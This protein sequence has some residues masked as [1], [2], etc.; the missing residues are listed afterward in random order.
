MMQKCGVFQD[1][2]F[3]LVKKSPKPSRFPHDPRT[4]RNR[5]RDRR[6]RKLVGRN[7]ELL[8]LEGM[9]IPEFPFGRSHTEG[10]R[11]DFP[12]GLPSGRLLPSLTVDLGSVATVP[13]VPVGNV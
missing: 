12:S 8:I 4:R 9:E 10:Q 5:S 2:W 11:A 13:A 1:D 7:D 6:K 3:G